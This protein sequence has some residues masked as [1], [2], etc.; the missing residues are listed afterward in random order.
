MNTPSPEWLRYLPTPLLSE[1]ERHPSLRKIL[2]NIGWLFLGKILRLSMGLFVGVW[3]ARYL[4]PEQF[5]QFSYAIAFVSLFAGI[6]TLGLNSIV[7]RDIVRVPDE[8]PITLGTAFLL[9]LISSLIA[10]TLIISTI[11]WLRPETTLTKSMVVI[12]GFS[13]LFKA[14][15]VIKYWFESQV[16]SKYTVWAENI[17]YMLVILVKIGM[18]LLQAPL[19]AFLWLALLEAIL[20][21]IALFAVYTKQK[22]NLRLW[23]V[24][25]K[26]AKS[27]IKDSWPLVL[28][29]IAIMIYMRMDQ[30]MLGEMVGNEAVGFYSAALRI[31][32]VWYMIPIVI[33]ASV[34]PAITKT[35]EKSESEYILILQKLYDLMVIFSFSIAL[36][37]SIASPWII[38]F[39]FGENYLEASTILSVHVWTLIFV[40]LGVAS[41]KWYLLEN[42]QIHAFYR[43]ISGGIANVILNLMLI[44]K[45][46]GVGAAF[47]TLVSQITATY[48]FDLFNEK[49]RQS[50][51]MKTASLIPFNRIRKFYDSQ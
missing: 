13:L 7:V 44:P 16:Q 9:Q 18:I 29:G 34:F 35:K 40:F 41:G 25:I 51:Y 39:L 49:T 48:L 32:E 50:F 8:A 27:L 37:I 38:R 30:V 11:N 17:V 28:S 31:S 10:I 33:V 43:A 21:A 19:I 12:L 47:A 1:I 36:P 26:R 5:G 15:E 46:G 4:G 23:T 22:G 6:A 20:I 24:R 45:F 14:S 2:T 3:L 42:L